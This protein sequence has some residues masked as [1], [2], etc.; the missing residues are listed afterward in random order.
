MR[1]KKHTSG[2]EYILAAG[3]WVRDLTKDAT[4]P[5]QLT[6]LYGSDDHPVVLKN[7]GLN[8][9]RTKIS[10]EQVSFKNVVIVSDGHEFDKRHLFLHKLPPDTAILA[11]NKA[12]LKWRLL[13]RDTPPERRR[14]INAYVVNNPYREAMAFMPTRETN[15]VPTC[16]ASTR[17][18]HEFV[19]KYA[20]DVYCYVPT[21]ELAFGQ[22]EREPYH[23]DDYRNPICAALGLAYQFGAEK[24]MLLCCDDSFAGKRD[25]AV[26]LDNG[27]YTYPQH[28][29]SH[30]IIEANMHWLTHQDYKEVEIADY[31]SGPEYKNAAYINSE[32]EALNFF[33][34]QQEGTQDVYKP[35]LATR[36]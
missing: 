17:T 15:H 31:S 11:V 35:S 24:I 5:L 23:I 19:R 1:I 2:N 32:E 3:V 34:D 22:S 25:F 28:L 14:A 13:T 20:G 10:E 16:I 18:N 21:P 36:V 26:R 29:K 4:T 8:R 33:R 7:E 27:L 9:N 6:H 12:M 30:A